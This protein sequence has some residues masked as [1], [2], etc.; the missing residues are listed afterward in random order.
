MI[1]AAV[2]VAARPTLWRT[3]ARQYRRTVP[4]RWWA[5]RPY[6][7]LPDRHYV[8]FRLLTQYGRIDRAPEP[9][10]VVNYLLWCAQWERYG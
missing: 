3:A 1:R 4:A 7:P 9:S 2:A 5:Q 8:E 6:L 10:D